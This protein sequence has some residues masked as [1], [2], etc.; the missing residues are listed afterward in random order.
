MASGVQHDRRI[1]GGVRGL[2]CGVRARRGPRRFW[3]VG[4]PVDPKQSR[5]NEPNNQATNQV[6]TE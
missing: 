5:A 2:F 4:V 6:T 1:E 3:G